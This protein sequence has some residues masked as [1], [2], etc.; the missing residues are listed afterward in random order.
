MSEATR[1]HSPAEV[2]AAALV[3]GGQGTQA[4]PPG[5]TSPPDVWPVYIG[6]LP[7]TPDAAIC[8]YDTAGFGEGRIQRT[9]ETLRKP[10]WQIRVRASTYPAASTRIRQIQQ[11]LDTIRMLGVEVDA[12]RY[13]IAAV[14]QTSDV[15]PLGQE[16]E[17]SRRDS[18]TL[19]GTITYKES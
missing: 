3:L 4:P 16:P 1:R 10:G 12:R 15:L 17:G 8:V 9:G 14:T 6:H 7:Q 11:H 13:T 18:F 2:L 19:N 5:T